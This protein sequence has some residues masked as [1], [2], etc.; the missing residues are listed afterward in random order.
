MAW[1]PG[2]VGGTAL[3]SL[4][5]G[6]AN[7]GGKLPVT[8]PAQWSDEPVFNGGTTTAFNYYVGYHYFDQNGT[9]PL[10]SFGA[11]MSYTTFQ[12]G[13][14]SV[15]C[16]TVTDGGVVEITA[17]VTNAG[18]VAGDEV[19][20]LFVSY[21]NTTVRRPAKELK[22]FVRETV[23]PGQTV[24]VTIPLRISDLKYWD[25]T[26]SSWQIE[27]GPVKIMVGGSSTNLPLSDTLLVQ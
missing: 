20:F 27:S 14:L 18:T 22:G 11:G 9:S 3:G 5:F 2:M 13:N 4:L 8:W 7:F 24:Q 16:A 17:N 1:Y 26:S 19:T 12:Y 25:T 21:P 15:P 23:Q 6:D 10:F